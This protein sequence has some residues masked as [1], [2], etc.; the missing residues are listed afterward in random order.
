MMSFRAWVK[1]DRGFVIAIGTFWLALVA[2]FAWIMLSLPTPSPISNGWTEVGDGTRLLYRDVDGV[3]C[4]RRY[5]SDQLS[6]V[7]LTP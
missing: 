4:F 2:T 6:C 1:R 7:R 5:Y 3:R